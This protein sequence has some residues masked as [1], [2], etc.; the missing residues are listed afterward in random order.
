[1]HHSTKG[2]TVE[3]F[4]SSKHHSQLREA[5]GKVFS[6]AG[7]MPSEAT[8]QQAL[9]PRLPA[10]METSAVQTV[11]RPGILMT[12]SNHL[13]TEKPKVSP[14]A[15]DGGGPVQ[16]SPSAAGGRSYCRKKLVKS[17]LKILPLSSPSSGE[18]YSVTKTPGRSRAE[19]L[20]DQIRHSTPKQTDMDS[21]VLV[22]AELESRQDQ[23]DMEQEEESGLNSFSLEQEIFTADR[24]RAAPITEPADG[25]SAQ[26]RKA[27][28][29]PEGEGPNSAQKEPLAEGAESEPLAEGVESEPLAEGVES[30]PLAEGAESEP[31][32][33]GVESEA[34]LSSGIKAAFKIFKTQLQAHF[35]GCWQKVEAEVLQ[36]LNECQQHVSSLLRAVNHHRSLLL[37]RF[38]SRVFNQLNQLEQNSTSLNTIETQVLS[39]F[40]SEVCSFSSFCDNQ[41]LRLK[42]LE[43]A[44]MEEKVEEEEL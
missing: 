20:F 32:A 40:Q 1:M 14:H 9:L 7:F 16:V 29:K 6:T 23:E 17:R 15:Q 35:T 2:Q 19:F 12:E 30:E 24:K 21:G 26:K 39:F 8:G 13:L 5:A 31:L 36:S 28:S 37:Q 41:Q 34:E 22:E 33:E 38:E 11:C 10:V 4:F 25:A 42:S 18:D 44:E 27:E 43:D 3:M